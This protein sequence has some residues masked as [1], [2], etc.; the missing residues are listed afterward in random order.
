MNN[1]RDEA[2]TEVQEGQTDSSGLSHKCDV[3]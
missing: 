1:N 3:E 2:A